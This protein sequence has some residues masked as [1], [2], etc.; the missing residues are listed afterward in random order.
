MRKEPKN[1]KQLLDIIEQ[2]MTLTSIM[3]EPRRFSD[4]KLD[5]VVDMSYT[6]YVLSFAKKWIHRLPETVEKWIEITDEY[7]DSFSGS[8]KFYAI[9]KWK[10]FIKEFG[11][12]EY[13]ESGNPIIP[14]EETLSKSFSVL[15]DIVFT[16]AVDIIYDTE[17]SDSKF[18]NMIIS[19]DT[20][21]SNSMDDFASENNMKTYHMED[22]KMVENNF[23]DLAL[24]KISNEMAEKTITDMVDLIVKT[25]VNLVSY[26]KNLQKNPKND[27]KNEL[28]KFRYWCDMFMNINFCEIDVLYN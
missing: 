5:T 10:E 8:W 13:D 4:L 15:S 22:S 18:I 16:D 28:T 12:D 11:A 14:D 1:L 23:G 26:I 7:L 17:L 9:E 27:Y 6:Y 3:T 2:E 19:S 25:V 20:I 21:I 24:N